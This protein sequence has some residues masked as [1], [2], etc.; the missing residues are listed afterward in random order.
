MKRFFSVLMILFSFCTSF[1]YGAESGQT[2]WILAA[3][4]F[5]YAQLRKTSETEDAFASLLPQL[6]LENIMTNTSRSVPQDEMVD[7]KLSEL[8]T[9]RISLFL[10]L[11]KETKVRD[12]LVVSKISDYELKKAIKESQSKITEIQ[13][14]IDANI[15]EMERVKKEGIVTEETKQMWFLPILMKEKVEYKNQLEKI[16][17]Y[18]D[19]YSKLFEASAEIESEGKDSYAFE[20][21]VVAQK[22]NGL[23]TGKISVYGNYVSVTVDIKRYPGRQSIGVITEVGF[24]SD[25]VALA[26]NIAEYIGPKIINAMPVVL[27]F[28]VQPR[29]AYANGNV[30][31][32]DTFYPKIPDELVLDGG[33]H[34]LTFESPGFK[35][36]SVTYNFSA[37]PQFTLDVKMEEAHEKTVSINLKKFRE[38]S[39]YANGVDFGGNSGEK[40]VDI[41]VNGKTVLGVFSA[42]VIKKEGEEDKIDTETAFFHINSAK[43]KDGKDYTLN[44]KPYD[45]A[46]N[47]DKRRKMMYTA[48]T[49]L[50]LSLPFTFFCLG[51]NNQSIEA[52]NDR[53]ISYNEALAWQTSTYVTEGISI[54]CGA[55]F[56]VELTR[57]LIAANE[58][59]PKEP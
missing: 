18:K 4:K 35:S 38:G 39:F 41:K 31:I 17:I 43:L 45:R 25:P 29:Q 7:R 24:F 30:I 15:E 23:L 1:F 50:T 20:K 33:I 53:R 28:W 2:D 11:S 6:I 46:K 13:K 32:D 16:K 19:D 8:Q 27:K 57:Y 42:K 5:S 40:S 48:F 9:D 3:R 51:M 54:A 36:E 21:E 58:V 59:L 37:V 34:T 14:K 12:A 26:K 22:I 10:Q 49:A 47:I 44:L 52:Y 56:I 55:W